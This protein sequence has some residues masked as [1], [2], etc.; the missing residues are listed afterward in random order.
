MKYDMQKVLLDRARVPHEHARLS[1]RMLRKQR[2]AYR[3][4]KKFKMDEHGDVCDVFS[5]RVLPMRCFTLGYDVN[6]FD[7]NMIPLRRYL[8]SC[9]GQPWDDIY[10]DIRK[11]LISNSKK[12]DDMMFFLKS[13]VVVHTFRS[14]DGRVCT[15]GVRHNP[16]D[17]IDNFYVE[18]ET[19]LLR[20]GHVKR[21]KTYST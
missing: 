2:N 18:P 13:N 10:S 5:S 17:Y 19:G 14:T 16:C 3:R 15:W 21:Q 11:H 8:Q 7:T 12:Q 6:M 20:A 4:A 9:V 1:A